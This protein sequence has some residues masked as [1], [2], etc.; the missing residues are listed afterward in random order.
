MTEDIDSIPTHLTTVVEARAITPGV[1]RLTLAGGL[2]RYRSAG[3]DSFVY[4]LL[5]PP[6]RRELTIGTDFTWTACFAMP[7]EER[8]V[9]AY[10]TVRHHRPDEGS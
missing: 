2:E 8:P 7:E 1:R 5:P 3:P 6:G 9:G 10:Y 4:V